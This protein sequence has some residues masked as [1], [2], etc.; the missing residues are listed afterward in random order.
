[1]RKKSNFNSFK[2]DFGIKS[3]IPKWGNFLIT[4]YLHQVLIAGITVACI[5]I[6][7]SLALALPP[8]MPPASG[9]MTTF[10]AGII[11]SLF[12]GVFGLGKLIRRDHY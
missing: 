9:L 7:F 10:I 4:R 6:P 2:F 5:A 12:G 1:M 3:L 8:G 11:C